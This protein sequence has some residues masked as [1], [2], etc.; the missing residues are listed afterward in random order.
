MGQ[1]DIEWFLSSFQ[2]FWTRGDLA[3][4]LSPAVWFEDLGL[5]FFAP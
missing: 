5:T 1:R 4:R 3:Y 2:A